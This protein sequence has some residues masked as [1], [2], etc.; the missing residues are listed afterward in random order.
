MNKST[1]AVCVYGALA[2]TLLTLAGQ[3]ASA[4]VVI[5]NF[6]AYTP[7]NFPSPTWQDVATV[8]PV[9]PP[10]VN[11]ALPSATVVNTHT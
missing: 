8:L 1:R 4:A 11:A 7:G 9:L 3:R 5:D 10:L 2:A 6:E